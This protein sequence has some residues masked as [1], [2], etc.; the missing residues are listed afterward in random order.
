MGPVLEK[1]TKCRAPLGRGGKCPRL[2]EPIEAPL[3]Y[4]GSPIIGGT[5]IGNIVRGDTPGWIG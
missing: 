5:H 1:C 2:C 3:P 4:V